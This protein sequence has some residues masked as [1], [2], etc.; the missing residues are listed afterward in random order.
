M[1]ILIYAY[2]DIVIQNNYRLKYCKHDILSDFKIFQNFFVPLSF[3]LFGWHG[4][5]VFEISTK[6]LFRRIVIKE[7][8]ITPIKIAPVL[9][10][11][12][13]VDMAIPFVKPFQKISLAGDICHKHKWVNVLFKL[14]IYFIIIFYVWILVIQ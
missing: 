1:Y 9:P 12:F 4:K 8:M 7:S 6:S 5:T 3:F 14:V 13:Y 2:I 11:H 10:S